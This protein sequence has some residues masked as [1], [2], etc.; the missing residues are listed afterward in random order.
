MKNVDVVI[1]G[2]GPA[3]M[4]C[5][6]EI[7]TKRPSTKVVILEMGRQIR[8][9]ICP[10]KE[11]G[12]CV[13]C[14]VCAITHGSAGAGAFSDGKLLLPK[15]TDRFVRGNLGK[16]L[17]VPEAR[18]LFGYTDQIYLN[19]GA[20]SEIKGAN[21][22]TFIKEI[23]PYLKEA[24][25][26]AR[27]SRIRHLG[28]DG[29]REVYKNLEDFLKKKGI[30]FLYQKKANDLIIENGQV[31]G[32]KYCKINEEQEES[33]VAKNVILAVGRSGT[34]WLEELCKKYRI[35]SWYGSADLGVRYELPDMVMKDINENLYEGKF[36][37]YPAPFQ[38]KVRTFCQ[39]PSGLVSSESYN[40]KLTLVNGHSHLQP[41]SENTNLALLV[42]MN[43]NGLTNPTQ[44]CEDV[45]HTINSLGQGQPL[46]QRLED[47]RCG[48]ATTPEVLLR[49]SVIPTLKSARPGDLS[50]GMPHRVFVDILG[51][52]A[53]M[54]MVIPGFADGD[55]LLYGPEAK[56]Y[57]LMLSLNKNCETS[58]KGLY[59]I[60]DGSGPTHGLMPAS[61]NGILLGRII[62]SQM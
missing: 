37:G 18:E 57:S 54:D 29:A 43:L 46:V 22:E 26:S 9:R 52:I 61:V 44:I 59:G 39:N 3:G 56:F 41:M 14:P 17:T 58:I 48:R 2:A 4:F 7:I 1:I 42:S 6:Y 50:L 10:E 34:K 31:I 36:I 35:K 32:V 12:L 28:T 38:D 20:T 47:L 49:N 27:S 13:K 25:L 16:H 55:N 11:K 15:P 53:Q 33:V 62:V 51:F 5:A 23:A 19:F 40:G 45:A 8:Q 21:A 24:G 60:G 30:N